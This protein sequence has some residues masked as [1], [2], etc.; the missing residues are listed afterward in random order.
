MLFYYTGVPGSGKT[1]KAV[2]HIYDEKQKVRRTL[3]VKILILFYK[4]IKTIDF[5]NFIVRRF[6]RTKYLKRKRNK[7]FHI[8]TNIDG[9]KFKQY[10]VYDLDFAEFENNIKKLYTFYKEHELRGDE[11]LYEAKRLQLYRALIVID[12]CHTV[13]EKRSVH[14]VW[15]VTY[16]RHLY[17]DIVFITQNIQLVHP[18]YKQHA[19]IYYQA[20][21]SKVTLLS[22][23]FTYD[24]FMHYRLYAKSKSGSIRVL[25]D[26]NIFDMYKSGDSVDG[27]SI[28]IRFIVLLGVVILIFVFIVRIFLFDKY[29]PDSNSTSVSDSTKFQK[30]SSKDVRKIQE[31]S[32]FDGHNK[33]ELI[34]PDNAIYARWFCTSTTCSINDRNIPIDIIYDLLDGLYYKPLKRQILSSS[35]DSMYFLHVIIDPAYIDL[36]DGSADDEGVFNPLQSISQIAE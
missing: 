31:S 13:L 20:R 21:K 18:Q 6:A 10:G 34:R 15:W 12:E 35:D 2:K 29:Y 25:K 4:L 19:E 7:K 36:F 1:Y 26:Q 3:Y 27:S 9:F 32:K 30:V 28:F 16:H 23:H 5:R 22:T 14:Y 33:N 8:Y 11:L 24:E 17:Q